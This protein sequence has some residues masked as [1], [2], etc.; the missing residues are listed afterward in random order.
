MVRHPSKLKHH[1]VYIYD[2]DRH[3]HPITITENVSTQRPAGMHRHVCR[4]LRFGKATARC[5][6]IA[7][8]RLRRVKEEMLE[9]G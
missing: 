7:R 9:M 6:R 8:K 5:P 4:G 3:Q 1:W 2:E